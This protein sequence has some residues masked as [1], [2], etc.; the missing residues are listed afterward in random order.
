MAE[1]IV[2]D[3]W[4]YEI[5]A[6]F[7]YT[8]YFPFA[9]G[10]VGTYAAMLLYILLY[11]SLQKFQISIEPGAIAFVLTIILLVPSVRVSA[12]AELKFNKKDPGF[13]VVDEVLGYWI[14]VAFLPFDWR[15]IILAFFIFRALDILKPFPAY[16]SQEIGDGWG[17]V[18][19]DLIVGLY[20][21]I[22]LRLLMAWGILEYI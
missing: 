17:I 10:T 4:F 18:L 2:K 7:G 13:V 14:S 12:W 8:G 6:T 9:S 11:L 21:N 5:L 1:K 15:I 20:T 22:I 19:D 3:N 16:I